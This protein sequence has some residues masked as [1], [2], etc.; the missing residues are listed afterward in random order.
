[1]R[2]T[3]LVLLLVLGFWSPP[4]WA[5]TCH[6]GWD[7]ITTYTDGTPATTLAGYRLYVGPEIRA[8]IPLTALTDASKPDMR[9]PC[10]SGEG[11][12][13]KGVETN[14]RE[15]EPSNTVIVP[16]EPPQLSTPEGFTL[17]EVEFAL[18]FQRK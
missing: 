2:N 14:G 11:W 9:V 7:A 4:V 8:D 12:Y 3:M 5:A 15:S 16:A 18:R 17:T 13:V 10:V 1:M 6:F